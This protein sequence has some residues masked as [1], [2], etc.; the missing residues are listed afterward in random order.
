M[1]IKRLTIRAMAGLSLW[2][3]FGLTAQGQLPAVTPDTAFKVLPRQPG[4]NVSTPG[5]DQIPQCKV[6]PIPG[7]DGKPMGYIVRDP[8]GR[9]V[10]QFVSYDG[11]TFNIIA[12]YLNGVEAYRESYPPQSNEPFQFRWLGPNGTKWGLDRDRDGRVDEWVVMSPEELSQE[13]LAAILTRDPKRAEALVVTRGNLEAIGVPAGDTQKLLE[14]AA[15]AS[16]RVNE[17]ADALKLSSN[18]QWV[19]LGLAAPQ[20]TAADAFS[21]PARDD[22]VMH[23]NGT[24]LVQDGKD[25]KFLQTGEMVLIG[26]AWKLVD[27]PSTG[28]DAGAAAGGMPPV[29][30]A[31]EGLLTKLHEVDS[32]FPN[33]PTPENLAAHNAK[34]VEILEQ[35]VAKLEAKDQETWLKLLA[36]A[37]SAASE[38]EKPGGKHITRLQQLRESIAKG[39]NTALGA[40]ITFRYLIAENSIALAT[41]GNEAGGF[42]VI[43]ARWRTNLEDFI[44]TYPTSE[45]APEA[46]LRLAMATEYLRD[47]E[48]KAKE[49][50]SRL[51][52]EYPR[53]PHAAKAA[54]AVKRLDS[55]GKPLE[56][57]GPRLDNGQAFDAANLRGKVVVVYYFA[58]WSRALAGD[59]Q[60][61]I[62]L[63]REYGPKDLVLIGVC[64]DNDARTAAQTVASFQVP[65]IILHAPGGLDASPLA[66]NYGI[67][68]VPHVFVVGKDGKIVNRNAQ[69]TT[70]EEDVKKLLK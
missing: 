70:V 20:A 8:I 64:L 2:A 6:E 68:V 32:Q 37:L 50:Y 55:E 58:S 44:K 65:G 60:K 59:V 13:L 34:R 42:D 1:V 62:A 53:H 11:K 22:V 49:W 40:Y 4:V 3:G 16:R 39:Q 17:V 21:P 61:L 18:A 12:F 56:L 10:R 29:P 38:G 19:Q 47:G 25:T 28:L 45:E 46:M 43:Q 24:V 15:T 30:K 9:A 57:V 54:G 5:P 26:R 23:R 52:R 36:D 35:I 31:I 33:P 48:S 67:V 7:K 66:A 51:A 14:R 63:E 69:A 27:G 41:T